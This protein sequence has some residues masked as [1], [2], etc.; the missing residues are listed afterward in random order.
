VNASIEGTLANPRI[1]GGVHVEN[2]SANYGDF[3]AGLS[4]LRGDF[5]FE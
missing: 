3:P 4:K 2:V 1:T 5:V